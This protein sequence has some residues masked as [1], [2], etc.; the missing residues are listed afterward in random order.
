MTN[1]DSTY[2][3]TNGN[4]KEP[5]N[6][7]KSTTTGTVIT[8]TFSGNVTLEA[9][10][11]INTNLS[12]NATLANGNGYS[13]SIVS[14]SRTSDGQPV[15]GWRDMRTDANTTDDVWTLTISG[16]SANVAIGEILLISD[17]FELGWLY[18][19]E[20]AA[21]HPAITITT[22]YGSK[23][24]YDTGVRVRR[25]NGTVNLESD[26]SALQTLWQATKGQVLPF[27]LVPEK[28]VNDAWC[29]RFSEAEFLWTMQGPTQTDMPMVLEELSN[30]LPL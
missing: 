23:T 18:G 10:A 24:M 29:V 12:V 17:L 9:I 28:A 27:L 20:F 13:Q 26:R 4:D 21:S 22:F 15:N 5:A 7:L 8:M 19:V 1:Q 11:I 16:N 14:P 2:P 6:P 25:A 30:G 3:A